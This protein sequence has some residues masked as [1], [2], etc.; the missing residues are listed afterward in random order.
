MVLQFKNIPNILTLLR[1]LLIPVFVVLLADVTPVKQ[2]AAGIIFIIAALTDLIDGII[3]RRYRVVSDFGK[4]LDP[5][6]DK[7]LVMAALVM[8]V[9]ILDL[10]TGYPLVPAWLV[11]LILARE[12]WITGVR[13]IAASKGII[14]QAGD[15]GK[16]KSFFQMLGIT[17]IF[18]K[19]S[20]THIF[21]Y[22]LQTH[23]I[24]LNLLFLSVLFA[25]LGAFE[26]TFHIFLYKEQ[27][28]NV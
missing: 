1:I 19:E 24:A 21:G 7:I 4:L 16:I 22:V 25:Y 5:L 13:G 15:F 6:A 14:L 28:D 10:E 9:G 8:F 20:S 3:A 26:Y 17:L 2:K 12:I 23:F 11:V 27:K 18:F